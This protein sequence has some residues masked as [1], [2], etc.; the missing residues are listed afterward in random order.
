VGDAS[1][2]ASAA[3][4]IIFF[5]GFISILICGG[6]VPLAVRK[7]GGDELNACSGLLALFP[8]CCAQCKARMRKSNAITAA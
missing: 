6:T 5:I 7:I 3:L 2:A 4:R 1:M 8:L